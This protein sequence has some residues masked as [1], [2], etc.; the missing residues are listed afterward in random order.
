MD[1]HVTTTTISNLEQAFQIFDRA[2]ETLSRSYEQLG[3]T[4]EAVARKLDTEAVAET[5]QPGQSAGNLSYLGRI[6]DVIPVA[7][8]VLDCDGITRYANDLARAYFG[9][10]L[11]GRAWRDLI[12]S[13]IFNISD[14]GGMKL[15]SGRELLVTTSP[16][17]FEPG[18]VVSF[19]DVTSTSNLR[20]MVDH[21]SRHS[22]IHEINATLAH[23]IRTPLTSALLYISQL[24]A[25]LRTE[26][27]TH[28]LERISANLTHLE[29]LTANILETI[30]DNGSTV[31]KS[32]ITEIINDV[33]EMISPLM[34]P[35]GC[36]LNGYTQGADLNVRCNG[37]T[38]KSIIVNMVMNS[39]HAC[40]ELIQKESDPDGQEYREFMIS[41]MAERYQ[42]GI[43]SHVIHLVVEDNGIGI[44]KKDLDIIFQPR[45]TTKSFGTGLGLSVAKA[46]VE[47]MNGSIE[48]ESEWLKGTRVTVCIPA[49]E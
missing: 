16:L 12:V 4:L 8:I 6:L 23:Q 48:I 26:K 42:T 44:D 15:S 45:F 32:D 1:E 43:G 5:I 29:K 49:A 17:G 21:Y 10:Q 28:Y 47:S 3:S 30:S 36:I 46:V 38:L 11:T 25:E 22:L 40:M 41:I 7:V 19:Y 27:G 13:G 39:I 18:Q 9:G 31:E 37:E 2:S 33:I 20:C 35:S 14:D 24:K 34:L